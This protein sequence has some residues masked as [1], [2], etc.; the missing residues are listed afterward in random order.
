M[1]LYIDFRGF[2]DNC[3][4]ENEN[5]NL[6][7][8]LDHGGLPGL[9][10]QLLTFSVSWASLFDGTNESNALAV[11]PMLVPVGREGRVQLPVGLF[12]WLSEHGS[13]SSSVII[14]LS[15]LDLAELK[16]RLAFRLNIRL[17]ENTDAMLRFFDPRVFQSLIGVLNVDQA[18]NFLGVAQRWWYVD[19]GGEL[20][21]INSN[22]NDGASLDELLILDASQEF[23][24]VDSCEVDHI[25]MSLRENA[26]DLLRKINLP[27][28]YEFVKSNINE[29]R[30]CGLQSVEDLI[31]YNVA[32][33][34]VGESSLSEEKWRD[35][36]RAVKLSPT[37]FSE[38]VLRLEQ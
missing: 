8:L 24:M 23:S 6:Y 1:S 10:Q 36:M 26:P 12:R 22:F 14:L 15:P 34:T 16:D 21:C 9:H 17:S 31:L 37:K 7:F 32:A 19:R 11:A 38:L 28:Q 20:N 4:A 2:A 3:V 30:N 5:S 35:L 25:L 29:A 33:L 13:Y 18:N 27:L